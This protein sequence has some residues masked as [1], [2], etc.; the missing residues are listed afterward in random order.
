[1]RIAAVDLGSN[2]FHMLGVDAQA[3]GHFV[4]LVRAK[5]MLRLGDVVSRL[6]RIPT[7][8]ADRA[9]A[10]M[11]RFRALADSAECEEIVACATSAIREAD[12]GG[13]LADR[14]Q[15]ETGIEVRVIT[16]AEEARLI[17]EAVRASVVIDPAPALAF[18]LGGGS[19]E[20]TVG[21]RAGLQWAASLKLGV[22]RL[23]AE[24]VRHDPPSDGDLK[25]L[26]RR[27]KEGLGTVADEVERLGPRMLVVTSGTLCTMA[28]MA[29]ARR[30]GGAVPESVNQMGVKRSE[31]DELHDE[32]IST[33]AA[34]RAKIKGLDEGRADIIVAGSTLLVTAM[35]M[36]GLDRLVASEWALREGMVLDAIAHHDS[37]DW[38]GDPRAIRSASVL[39]LCRRC[40]WDEEHSRQV[41]RL[42]L[43]I[44]DETSELH[45]MGSGAR[46]LLV[47]AGHLH[48]IGA[49]VS[50]EG[51]HKHSAYLIRHGRLRGF[52]PYEVSMLGAIARHHRGGPPKRSKEP[53]SLVPEE[54][55]E[56]V[57]K[58]TAL[59]RLADGLDKARAQAVSDVRFEADGQSARLVVSADADI[60]VDLWG[61]RRKRQLF[62]SV[63]DRHL[64]VIAG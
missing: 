62:E 3:D 64:D 7:T 10:T 8:A 35:D 63:F 60:D 36:F 19:L 47:H 14:I 26:R 2:S 27:C 1:M 16:G 37:A 22:A 17:F 50:T 61:A 34:G 9:V 5:E 18:D 42:A 59:L 38:S 46:E 40:N 55:Q 57:V 30:S 20:V 53:F 51:H 54:H 33:S 4:P 23:T 11:S 43:R 31:I 13:E 56:D 58:L 24:L 29:F 48:D 12:N 21:D 39:D 6:G 32:L 52:P 41:A 44:F 45:G 49:H 25:R 15:A 28:R